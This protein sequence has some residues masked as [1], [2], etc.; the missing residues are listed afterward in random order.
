VR[1]MIGFVRHGYEAVA[2]R[3]RSLLRGR[4]AAWPWFD[5]LA[6]A[7][8]CYQDRFGDR[9]AAGLTYYAFLAL[10]P[11]TALAFAVAGYVV[12]VYPHA[13]EYVTRAIDDILPGMSDKL[14][15]DEIARA[16]AGAG[17]IGLALLLWGGLGWVAALRGALR[18]IWAV[19]PKAGGSFVVKKLWDAA[20]LVLLGF[21]LSV[22]VAMSGFTTSATPAVLSKLGL[23]HVTGAD[24]LVRLLSLAIAFGTDVIVFLV[25]FSRLSGTR[26][27]WRGLLRGALFGAV[28]LE[29]LK[30]GGT[31]LIGRTTRNPVYASFAVTIGLLVWINLVSR[32]ILLAA[33]WT[34]AGLPG[35]PGIPPNA[36]ANERA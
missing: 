16:K 32:V 20:T 22:S 2:E 21:T 10:F 34:V 1:K 12:A 25:M 28:G 23:D 9:L 11:L 6:R 13:G 33:S 35:T 27:P 8:E 3:F 24:R 29:A 17:I 26:A 7:H 4:R 30:L 15:I 31:Y 14:P 19:D 36:V 5:H 18:S